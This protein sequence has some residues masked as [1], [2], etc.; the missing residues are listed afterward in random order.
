MHTRT[1]LSITAQ[2]ASQREVRTSWQYTSILLGKAGFVLPTVHMCGDLSLS[3][4]EVD[5]A[6]DSVCIYHIAVQMLFSYVIS[7]SDVAW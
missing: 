3:K 6:N 5:K 2:L 1:I 7:F 4:Q